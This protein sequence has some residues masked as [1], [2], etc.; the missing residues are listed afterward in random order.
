MHRRIQSIVLGGAK[1][2]I[3][4]QGRGP[5]PETKSAESGGGV[6]GKGAA[7]PLPTS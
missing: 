6:L 5:K 7:S 4:G 3:L 2:P 1:P